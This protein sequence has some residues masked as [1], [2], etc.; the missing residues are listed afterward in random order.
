[1]V[2]DEAVKRAMNEL[3]TLGGTGIGIER[4]E[5]LEA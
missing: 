4:I 2:L 5:R 3:P 1:M